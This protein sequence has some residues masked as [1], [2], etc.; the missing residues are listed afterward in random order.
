MA[1]WRAP[2]PCHIASQIV[3]K[4]LPYIVFTSI[5]GV[6]FP[7]RYRIRT[8]CCR[9]L[10]GLE[11]CELPNNADLVFKGCTVHEGEGI[12]AHV[13]VYNATFSLSFRSKSM[14]ILHVFTKLCARP[15]Q[16]LST[17]QN[18]DGNREN[19]YWLKSSLANV[20]WLKS[21]SSN[22]IRKHLIIVKR[23]YQF[24]NR[25]IYTGENKTRL[26]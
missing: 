4:Q 20:Y 14:L 21:S 1:G 23:H 18:G 3:H 26:R 15:S 9:N 8:R 13:I 6:V 2:S 10:S 17:R 16:F 22:F 12:V 5:Y 25:A 24:Y 11:F 19:V 7:R